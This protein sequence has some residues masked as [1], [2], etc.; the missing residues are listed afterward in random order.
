MSTSEKDVGYTGG[1]AFAESGASA[2]RAKANIKRLLNTKNKWKELV[3]N[4]KM[5]LA[6][7]LLVL[8]WGTISVAQ[9]RPAPPPS[10]YG[11]TLK[12]DTKALPTGVTAREVRTGNLARYFIKNTSDVP[13]VIN[14]RFQ[15]DRLVSGAKLVSGKVFHYFPNGVP[16][17]GKQHLKGWQAPFGDIEQTLLSLPKDPAKI[18][19][20]RKP[21][22]SKK[23]P[24]SEPYQ[25]P[26]N[27]DGKPYKIK[28]MIHYHLNPAYDAHNSEK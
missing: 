19:E 20:G 9:G 7:L 15:G 1:Q 11:Y 8:L 13:L 23:L 22:L 6:G 18:Y 10:R 12:I 24:P 2:C 5:G 17:Q 25:I 14:E 16:M 28:V 21:G 3:V 26:A 27:Y 4:K